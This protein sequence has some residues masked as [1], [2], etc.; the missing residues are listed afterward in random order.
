MTRD[1]AISSN[2]RIDP[3]KSKFDSGENKCSSNLIRTNILHD[4][5]ISAKYKQI[6]AVFRKLFFHFLVQNLAEEEF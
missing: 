2:L 3:H 5:Q 6:C 1:P 4:K